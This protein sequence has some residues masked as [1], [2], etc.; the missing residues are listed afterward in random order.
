MAAVALALL[1]VPACV[2]AAT[3]EKGMATDGNARFTVVTPN[4][5]RLEYTASGHFIDQESLFAV[6]R[7][8]RD[9]QAHITTS[10]GGV[11][12]DTG[13]IQLTYKSDGK[14]FDAENLQA[15]IR[16]GNA[17]VGW[18]PGAPNPGNLGGT[19]RTLDGWDGAGDLGQGV[20]SR[21]GWYLLDDST[22]CLLT[23]DW[24]ESRP[25][26][27]GL[28][29]YLFGYGTDYRAALK[30][31]TTISGAVPL[32]R[33]YVMGAWYSRYWPYTEGQFKEIVGQYAQHDFPLDMIVMDM[34]WHEAGWTGWSWNR[35]LIPHPTEL[36]QWFHQ[37]GLHVTLNSH[38]ADGV[39]PHEDCYA[40]F[41]Q[42]MGEDPAS[43]R[44]IP[45]DAGS[46]KYMDAWFKATHDPLEKQGV[47]FWWLDW[48]QYPYTRSIPDLTNLFWLNRCYYHH[49]SEGGKRGQDL[50]R[51]AGWG[52][53]RHPVHFSG[54]ASTSFPMLAFEVAM[55]ATAGNV[56]CFFWSHDIGG[57]NRGRNEESYT[58][59]CQFGATSAALRSH[60]TRDATMDR[61]PWTYPKWAEDSMR[62]SFHM[63][64]QLFPYIYT[65]ASESC[66]QTLPL[67][68]PMYIEY[69]TI[70]DAYHNAQ[71]Y[72]LGD[73]LLVAPIVSKGVGPGR[74]GEQVVWLP[75]GVWYNYFTGERFVG[76]S[77]RLVSADINE[78][79]LYV[80]G[81]APVPMQPYQSRMTTAPLTTLR[82][83]CYP[84]ED[85]ASQSYTL[86]EDDGVT[87]AYEQGACANTVLTCSRRG[88]R[89]T[90]KIGPATGH[91]A[92]QPV[93]RDY[94]VE[95]ADTGPATLVTVDGR[96]ATST[97]DAGTDVNLVH[98]PA[99]A[100]DR[101]VSVTVDAPDAD[102]AALHA[103]AVARRI[104][105]V[106][107]QPVVADGLKAALVAA[108]GLDPV[109]QASVLAAAG[110]GMFRKN[111]GTYLYKG[112][113]ET[114]F[115]STGSILDDDQFRTGLD[116]KSGSL[117]KVSDSPFILSGAGPGAPGISF[118][119]GGKPFS[120][121]GDPLAAPGNI[122]HLAKTT[123][124]GSEAGYSPAGLTDGNVSGYPDD[125]AAEWSAGATVGAWFTLTWDKMQ[126]VNRI[127]LWDRPN[128]TD[129][130]TGAV[131]TFSDGST[132]NVGALPDD[133]SRPLEL[134]FPPKQITTLTF[135]VTSVK[136]GTQNAGL[137]EIAVFS[138]EP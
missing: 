26:D 62:I 60:S 119:I 93:Q 8:A 94:V 13:A 22:S 16:K 69:P 92:G 124:S 52:D 35:D 70:E 56:G 112:K 28:D 58:R 43:K 101:T 78:F 109:T 30:S 108:S 21:D 135:R 132:L 98:V 61:R 107:G 74:V 137:A 131:I 106:T 75:K 136:P 54:D 5:I 12:I 37:Q 88:H 80:R 120:L 79:P 77:E 129:Q 44:T 68:R 99:E 4:C 64:S 40:Q 138:A 127:L 29:W 102:F 125:K 122:A 33:K 116:A 128:T 110:I 19:V 3:V 65:S 23:Q 32:P 72:F 27:S 105:G 87:T 24:V 134:K 83:R 123:V 38:P 115:Y 84:G 95:L 85:D 114:R 31:L 71:E 113:E 73:N 59:W 86:Y 133:A 7:T 55:T 49:T 51:W 82:V 17:W 14:P 76:P 36:L 67:L 53:Q 20:L 121:E 9:R 1:A 90:V 130:V 50:S 25:K 46:Q 11:Q 15:R 97:Y 118:S 34:D 100:I 91:Y 57:H 39:A 10:D 126:T 47:D 41:M 103:T 81:G 111:L 48:Q 42:Y 89:Y 45:F 6:G 63:R 66:R 96:K 117:L 2:S 104:S 18:A